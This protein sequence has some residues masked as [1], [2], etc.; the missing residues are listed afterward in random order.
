MLHNSLFKIVFLFRIVNET[1]MPLNEIE[2]NM[3][4]KK[5]SKK[6]YEEAIHFIEFQKI[7]KMKPCFTIK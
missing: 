1:F 7:Q 5:Q 4:V 3:I 6:F 2:G